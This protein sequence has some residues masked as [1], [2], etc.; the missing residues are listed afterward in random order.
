[1]EIKNHQKI[2]HF[3][4]IENI[5]FSRK[6]NFMKEIYTKIDFKGFFFLETT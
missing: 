4:K 5:L 1:M 6:Y 3:S 2:T